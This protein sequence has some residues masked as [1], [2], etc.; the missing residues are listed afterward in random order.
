LEKLIWRVKLVAE[1]GNGPAME[2]EV[3][4]IERDPHARPETL[5]L[6]LEEGKRIAAAVQREVAQ[7]QASVMGENSRYCGHCQSMLPSKGYRNMTFRSLYGDVRLRLRR[8]VGCQCPDG[9]EGPKTLSALALEGGIS[10]EL[11]YVTA[12]F[13]ALAPFARAAGML[14]ELLP[15]G[16]A[17]NAGTVRN[18]THRVGRCRQTS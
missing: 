3:A 6:T 7:A 4:R 12:K 16:G 17:I 1:M 10:P 14:A 15:V 8:F 18:R 11:A 13:A 9:C 2:V 5:G